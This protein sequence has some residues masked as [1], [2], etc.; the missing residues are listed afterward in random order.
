LA[1]TTGVYREWAPPLPL[2]A[3][4]R[5]VWTN[6][7]AAD[8]SPTVLVVPDGCIDILW[9]GEGLLVA[10]PDTRAVREIVPLGGRFVGVR[11]RPGAALPWLRT[12]AADFPNT[13]LSLDAFWGREAE[14]L[15][16]RLAQAG[17]AT[18][19]AQVLASSLLD[20][21]S[22]VA[23]PDPAMRI[24]FASAARGSLN[25]RKL[26]RDLGISERTLRRRSHEAFG[27]GPRTLQR[28]LR[29]QRFLRLVRRSRR[30]LLVDLAVAAGF[31]DQAHLA[32]E[33]RALAG[34]T[35][36]AFVE[37]HRG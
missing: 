37:A 9:A 5:C 34:L 17:D 33:V 27:Y 35:P 1:G 20:R 16:D 36:S 26:A 22:T 18:Q 14:D 3:H 10:G 11:F 4:I 6:E 28:I 19:S 2:Q 13:R 24:V 21:L 8:A 7:V 15:A 31:A 30:P 23:A 25:V 32:R 12:S 29:F